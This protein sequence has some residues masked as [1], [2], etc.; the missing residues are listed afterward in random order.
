MISGHQSF[1]LMDLLGFRIQTRAYFLY[2]KKKKIKKG[3]GLEIDVIFLRA[4]LAPHQNHFL[5]ILM[6]QFNQNDLNVHSR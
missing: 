6:R 3:E 5:V 1:T 2:K 4:L